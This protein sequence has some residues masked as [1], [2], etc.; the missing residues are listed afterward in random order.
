KSGSGPTGRQTQLLLL[1]S[2]AR[3]ACVCT[4]SR[5]R[6]ARRYASRERRAE[7]SAGDFQRSDAAPVLALRGTSR[8]GCAPGGTPTP[9]RPCVICSSS[10]SDLTTPPAPD[11]V[12]E[13]LLSAHE[14]HCPGFARSAPVEQKKPPQLSLSVTCARKAPERSD[15]AQR[16]VH[17]ARC[18]QVGSGQ[19]PRLRARLGGMSELLSR[20]RAVMPSWMPLYYD[21]PLEIVSGKG[22]RVVDSEGH[23]YLD[24]FTGIATNMLGYDVAEVRAAVEQQLAKGIVH[25][26]TLYLIRSQVELAEKIARLSEIPDA[27][28]FFTNSGTEANETAL[29]L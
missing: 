13:R 21:S 25:T 24:F 6:H 16:R 10:C 28:V 3:S 29:L 18:P 4:A 5:R 9:S 8:S 20:H 2:S 17:L 11:Q 14:D 22:S 27:K 15:P 19:R 23:T 26:S 7:W 1:I 12:T